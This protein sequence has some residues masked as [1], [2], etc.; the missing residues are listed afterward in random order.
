MAAD[1]AAIGPAGAR[2][3]RDRTQWRV[4]GCR[5]LGVDEAEGASQLQAQGQYVEA[6]SLSL[7]Q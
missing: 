4:E 3:F 6:A 2:R 5:S 1:P 7:T